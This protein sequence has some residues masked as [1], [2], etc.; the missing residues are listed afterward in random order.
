MLERKLGISAQLCD[1][2]SGA[3]PPTAVRLTSHVYEFGDLFKVNN[4][5]GGTSVFAELDN[6]VGA[7]CKG[8]RITLRHRGD[9]IFQ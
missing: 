4:P 3:D 6:E 7:T 9:R 8:A 2:R 1:A 5:F